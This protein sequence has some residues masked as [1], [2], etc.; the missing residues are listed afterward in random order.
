M[1]RRTGLIDTTVGE[2][3]SRIVSGEWPVG[4]RI[5]PEPALVDL[6]GVG[7]NTVREA[8][9]SLVHAGLLA[10][11]QGSG[12]FVLSTSEMAVT[13]GRHIA[14]A[15]QRDVIE[16]RRALELEAARLAARRRSAE[17]TNALLRRRDERAAAYKAGDLERMVSTDLD[18][19]R[20]IVR[21]AG[22]PVLNGLYENLLDAIGENIRFNFVTDTHGH[23]AHDGLVDAI[24]A[25]DDALAVEETSRYLSA[26]LGER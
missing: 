23:D 2:L 5:P 19:H 15:R 3:R 14:E 9:Q 16:V 8:V 21:T 17:D 7:R 26:L 24:V 4:S 13:M 10:R 18:L 1:T 12:T 11:R 20:L 6:L 22:N 25:G